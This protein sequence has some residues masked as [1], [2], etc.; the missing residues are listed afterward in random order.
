MDPT[1]LVWV[2]VVLAPV[3]SER[4]LVVNIIVSLAYN[5]YNIDKVGP[6]RSG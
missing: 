2:I 5:D 3:K 6:E 1:S 4:E